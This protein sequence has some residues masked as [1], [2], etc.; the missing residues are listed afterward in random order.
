MESVDMHKI[1]HPLVDAWESEVVEF[2]EASKD[3][4]TPEIYRYCSALS[5]EANLRGVKSACLVF[6]VRNKD[7]QIVGTDFRLQ[8]DQLHNLK[9]QVKQS[10]GSISF[11]EIYEVR[12]EGKR[13]LLFEPILPAHSPLVRV[14]LAGRL[15]VIA[16]IICCIRKTN[17]IHL[18]FEA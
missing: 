9:Q 11:R 13:V 17:K 16:R 2:T 14:G 10:T 3:Y 7:K 6:G 12:E 4:K 18:T 15:S 5:N 8:H 1:L